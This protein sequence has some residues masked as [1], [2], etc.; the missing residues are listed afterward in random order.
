VK[1]IMVLLF[2]G[3]F[4]WFGFRSLAVD[5][6][7]VNYLNSKSSVVSMSV[8]LMI[9]H[10]CK[11]NGGQNRGKDEECDFKIG[12]YFF[13]VREPFSMLVNRPFGKVEIMSATHFSFS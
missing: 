7:R 9:L 1:N 4:A 3:G 5:C 11:A 13:R 10:Q 6:R 12:G 8:S 2:W